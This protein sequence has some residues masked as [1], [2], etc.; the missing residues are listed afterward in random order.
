[1]KNELPKRK[2]NRLNKFDY[3]QKGAY[4]ITIC[5]HNRKEILSHINVGDG[6]PVPKL[7]IYGD[8]VLRLINEI[9]NKYPNVIVDKYVIM[10]NHIH[11]IFSIIND[12]GTGDPSPTISNIVAWLKYTSTKEINSFTKSA[13]T[14]IFQRSFYD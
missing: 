6:S 10:P 1:M 7:T 5:T 11:I 2:P 13:S 3:S 9:S 14:R 8:I 12:S 4:F